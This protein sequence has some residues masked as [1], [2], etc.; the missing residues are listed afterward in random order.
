MNVTWHRLPGRNLTPSAQF[1]I[2]F[3]KGQLY[4][5]KSIYIS[6]FKISHARQ[7]CRESAGIYHRPRQFAWMQDTIIA[8]LIA[9]VIGFASNLVQVSVWIRVYCIQRRNGTDNCR[10]EKWRHDG[11]GPAEFSVSGLGQVKF[12]VTRILTQTNFLWCDACVCYSLQ[13]SSGA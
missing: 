2:I 3:F 8:K 13:W 6:V 1:F 7:A 10:H 4:G 11:F 9:D 12:S 5:C